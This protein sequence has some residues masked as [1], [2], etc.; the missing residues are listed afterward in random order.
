MVKADRKLESAVDEKAKPRRRRSHA[1]LLAEADAAERRARE[2]KAALI[3]KSKSE[4]GGV[5]IR[6]LGPEVSAEELVEM[7]DG[8]ELLAAFTTAYMNVTGR[9]AHP[10]KRRRS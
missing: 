5:I 10:Y 2:R 6:V 7:L 9:Q 1:E 3:E 8:P 4:L